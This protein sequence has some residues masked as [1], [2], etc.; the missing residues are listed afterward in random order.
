MS[1]LTFTLTGNFQY[2]VGILGLKR[3]L[4]FFEVEHSSDEYSITIPDINM[5][6]FIGY[7][8][9]I[10]GY[11]YKGIESIKKRFKLD[12]NVND[13]DNFIKSKKDCSI[14]DFFNELENYLGITEEKDKI[15]LVSYPV[16]SVFNTSHLNAF[17][18]SCKKDKMS[19]YNMYISRFTIPESGNSDIC[20]FCGLFPGY[21]MNR[22]NFLFAPSAMNERWFEKQDYKICSLCS[23]LNLFSIY[24]MINT[25]SAE[26]F[27]IYSSNLI[28]MD[29]DNKIIADNFEDC[30]VKYIED[31]S[32]RLRPEVEIKNKTFIL[33]LLNNQ[34]PAIDFLPLEKKILKFIIENKQH[35]ERLREN[36]IVGKINDFEIHCFGNTIKRLL[37]GERLY[38]LADFI[39]L[40]AIKQVSGNKNLE[41]FSEKAITAAY[42]ILKLSIKQQGGSMSENVL[43][44]FKE[45]GDKIRAK[46]FAG[47]SPNAAK[48]KVISFASSIRDAVNESKE[49]FMEVILQ[50]S[51]YSDAPLP[52]SLLKNINKPDFNY[53][54]AGLALALSLLSY[55]EDNEQQQEVSNE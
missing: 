24:G 52:S 3:V 8:G 43:N 20:D 27:L 14:E 31:L 42:I 10:Y 19:L 6:P 22:N 23:S 39:T 49:R 2:D 25:K 26:K 50:L 30:F 7:L 53:K 28:D 29:N 1:V 35:I 13:F 48:N 21:P 4:D 36:N 47:K 38:N 32:V 17:N 18:P 12:L 45:F 11:K 9:Y 37:S 54:E 40:C 44:D 55:R 46:L 15:D 41:G 34:K 5:W 33:M 16:L 51:I